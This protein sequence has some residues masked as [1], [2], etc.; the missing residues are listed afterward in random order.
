MKE[1]KK[2]FIQ[3]FKEFAIKGNA[4]DLAIGVIIGGAFGAIINS[5]VN[6]IL[7]PLLSLLIGTVNFENLSFVKKFTG[8]DGKEASLVLPYG[9]F[10]QAVFN[11]L[12]I[13]LCIFLLVK[14]INKAKAKM[15]KPH[16]EAEKAPVKTNQEIVLEEIRDELKKMNK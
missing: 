15:T 16:E 13:A 3:E 9:K 2:S 6:D 14:G 1:N 7:M 12:I 5:L 4:L 11:F 8:L 10:I